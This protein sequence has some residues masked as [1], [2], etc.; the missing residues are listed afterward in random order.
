MT[1]SWI[2][3]AF[4]ECLLST[5]PWDLSPSPLP[6]AGY[7]TFTLTLKTKMRVGKKQNVLR[8]SDYLRCFVNQHLS[9]FSVHNQSPGILLKSHPGFLGLSWGLRFCISNKL[10]GDAN[11][12]GVQT[13]L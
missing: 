11:A 2:Q 1:P 5:S 9:N 12:A 7:S 4:I 10:P 3:Q 13:M 6:H 8:P